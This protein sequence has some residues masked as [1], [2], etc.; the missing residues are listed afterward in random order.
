MIIA[1]RIL[2]LRSGNA[3]RE[4]PIRIFAPVQEETDWSCRFEL[5]WPDG[6]LIRAAIGIDA[7]HALILALRMIGTQLYTS[8]HHAT[9]ALAWD[10]QGQGYGFPV[11]NAIRDLLVGDDMTF[12]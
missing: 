1:T 10:A 12:M 9:G 2:K 8:D 4:V 7:I 5:D 3:A 6:T 11:A